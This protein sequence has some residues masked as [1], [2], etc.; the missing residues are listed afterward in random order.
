M[1]HDCIRKL[2]Q[3]R[4]LD[5]LRKVPDV[6]PQ[7]NLVEVVGFHHSADIILYGLPAAA[8]DPAE[9][10]VVGRGIVGIVE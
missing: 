10:N 9:R 5:L 8:S 3:H 7:K 1:F 6:M 2:A 4:L